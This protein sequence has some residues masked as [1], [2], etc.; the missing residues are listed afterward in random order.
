M[1]PSPSP[2]TGCRPNSAA[3]WDSR[4]PTR[5]ESREPRAESREPR[6]ESREPRAESREP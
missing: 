2:P 1:W 6:A 3:C 5:A 4:I